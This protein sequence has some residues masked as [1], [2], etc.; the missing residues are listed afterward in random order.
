ME[1]NGAK[2]TN[3]GCCE[4]TDKKSPSI[5]SPMCEICMCT[6][7]TRP[8]ADPRQTPAVPPGP[9]G[10]TPGRSAGGL[11]GVRVPPDPQ[12]TPARDP[13]QTPGRVILPG[14]PG[15]PPADPGSEGGGVRALVPYVAPN[16]TPEI[17]SVQKPPSAS[18]LEI[19]K[20]VEH[21]SR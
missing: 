18:L 6:F 8:P 13:R 20:L 17:A 19:P 16:L 7:F 10:R 1:K 2:I 3:M 9:L 4:H 11:P 21:R 5:E 14:G 12:H 15:R